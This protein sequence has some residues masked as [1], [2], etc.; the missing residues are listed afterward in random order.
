MKSKGDVLLAVKQFAKE[1]GVPDVLISDA[2]GENMSDNLR[3][4]CSEIGTML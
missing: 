3:K 4:F 1:V 2:A